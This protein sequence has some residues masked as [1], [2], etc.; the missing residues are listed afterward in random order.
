MI[1]ALTKRQKETLVRLA[2]RAKELLDNRAAHL[3][4]LQMEASR[5]LDSIPLALD[6]LDTITTGVE[7]FRKSIEL[8]EENIEESQLNDPVTSDPNIYLKSELTLYQTRYG[9]QF[10]RME[11]DNRADEIKEFGS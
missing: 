9:H 3:Q 5:D 7:E 8:R 6:E 2:V 10:N 1:N 11:I 4:Y